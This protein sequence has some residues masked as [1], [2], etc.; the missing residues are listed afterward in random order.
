MSKKAKTQRSERDKPFPWRCPHCREKAVRPVSTSYH[1]EVKHDGSLHAFAIPELKIP[2]CENCKEQL[3]SKSVDDQITA[4]LRHHLGILSPSEIRDHLQKLGLA[5]RVVASHLGIAEATIS[6][7]MTGTVV[8]SI[9]LDRF[10]RLYFTSE[11]A[12]SFLAGNGDCVTAPD[13]TRGETNHPVEK[14]QLLTAADAP[15]E[16]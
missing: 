3:F 8:Q 13:A 12:R 16:S 5:Q 1:A 7:W 2:T 14:F 15:N 4:G 11:Q 9:A 10:L 6:R